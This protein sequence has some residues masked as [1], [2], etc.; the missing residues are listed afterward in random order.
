MVRL[1]RHAARDAAE[2]DVGDGAEGARRGVVPLAVR[3]RGGA[4]RAEGADLQAV[5]A[6]RGRRRGSHAQEGLQRHAAHGALSIADA[7]GLQTAA[8][9][10]VALTAPVVAPPR[11]RIDVVEGPVAHVDLGGT[12]AG[13]ARQPAARSA[14]G[15]PAEG[16]VELVAIAVLGKLT[17]RSAVLAREF[18]ARQRLGGEAKEAHPV[19]IRYALNPKLREACE[20]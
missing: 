17:V 11:A 14:A 8:P 18:R 9:A 15:R 19:G 20:V 16:R 10:V 13:R 2:D 7:P 4:P 1:R 3:A 12:D 5:R 6:G